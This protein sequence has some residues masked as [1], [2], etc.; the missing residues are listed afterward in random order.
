MKVSILK[1]K[2]ILQITGAWLLQGIPIKWLNPKALILSLFV[3]PAVFQSCSM[4]Q[5]NPSKENIDEGWEIVNQE[6]SK[7]PP[8]WTI[9]SRKKADSKFKEFKISGNINVPPDVAIQALREKTENSQKY[10]DK[11]TGF[12]HVLSSTKEEALIYSVFQMPFPFRNRA[13]CERF[14]FFENKETGVHKITWKEDWK[15]APLQNS[16]VIRMPIARGSWEF[17]PKGPDSSM[18]TYIVH[19]DPGGDIPSWMVNATVSKGLPDELKSVEEI[20]AILP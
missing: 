5:M 19:A 14:L 13:M 9:Y 6:K 8:A 2:K 4:T 17:V 11:K 20:A 18:A 1:L 15:A 10:I 16:G 3:F 7:N 12:I